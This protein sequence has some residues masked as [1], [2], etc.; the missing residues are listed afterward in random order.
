MRSLLQERCELEFEHYVA[1]V[2]ASEFDSLGMAC[3]STPY[4]GQ[5]IMRAGIPHLIRDIRAALDAKVWF[6]ERGPRWARPLPMGQECIALL[7][8]R[9]AL[10]LLGLYGISLERS[11]FDFHAHPQLHDFGCGVMASPHAPDHVRDDP[12]LRKEFPAKELLGL[13]S[14]LVWSDPTERIGAVS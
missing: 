1:G 6:S 11:D 4:G 9:G 2:F 10:H 12:E 14:R 7:Q 8:A 13:C 5:G 3:I